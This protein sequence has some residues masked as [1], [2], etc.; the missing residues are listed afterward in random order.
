MPVTCSR[1]K[2]A[3]RGGAVTKSS[4]AHWAGAGGRAQ[5]AKELRADCM[6][7]RSPPPPPPPHASLPV[8]GGVPGCAP[9]TCPPTSRAA[10]WDLT[11]T[12]L[13]CPAPVP[14]LL[15]EDTGRRRGAEPGLLSDLCS[16]WCPWIPVLDSIPQ[17]ESERSGFTSLLWGMTLGLAFLICKMGII[18]AH[19]GS[20]RGSKGMRVTVASHSDRVL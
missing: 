6:T 16:C 15:A 5:K 10:Q 14:P 2:L 3:G 9:D 18:R 17:T 8:P 13:T 12:A 4:Q 19:A 1:T 20:L 7:V 11:P